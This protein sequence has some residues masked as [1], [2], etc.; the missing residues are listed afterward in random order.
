[1]IL[2]AHRG[3]T[4]GPNPK[5]ENNPKYIDKAIDNGY[6]VEIDV[7]GNFESGFFLGHDHPQYE[8]SFDWLFERSEYLWVH[9]KDIQSLYVFTQQVKGC[10]AFWHESDSHTLT[11]MGFIWAYP[12]NILTPRSICVMPEKSSVI[13]SERDLQICAGICSDYVRQY[14]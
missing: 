8:V 6:N 3:N 11:T 7:R 1:M 4:N 5:M 14:K 2:I 10:N 12:G 9:S 13:Y